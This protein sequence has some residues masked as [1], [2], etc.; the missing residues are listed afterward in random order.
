MTLVLLHK[1]LMFKEVQSGI[2]MGKIKQKKIKHFYGVLYF[3]SNS[4]NIINLSHSKYNM[5][6]FISKNY[7]LA[8]NFV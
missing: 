8:I 6:L 5:Y 4:N 3:F 7:I 1:H 2:T